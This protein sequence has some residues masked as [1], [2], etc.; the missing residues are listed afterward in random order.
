MRGKILF[1]LVLLCGLVNEVFGCTG[2]LLTSEDK[3]PVSGRTVEFGSDIEMSLAVIPRNYTFTGVTPQG[4]GLKYTAK[5]GA[6]GIYCFDQQVLM[7]GIN[8]KG[9]VAAAFYFPG[10]ASY[11]TITKQNQS[12]ALSPVEFP[13]WILTQFSTIEEVKAALSSVVI[14]PTVFKSW[15]T[16][17]PPMHY[18][19]YDSSGKSLVIEPLNGTL[20]HHENPL[21]TFTNSPTFDWHL[22][23]LRN[24][25]NLSIYNVDPT[26]IRDLQLAPFGQGSGLVGLPGDFT[27]PSRFVRA[28]LFSSAALPT[29]TSEQAVFETF[30]LLNQFDIPVAAVREKE[31]KGFSYDSTLLTSVKDPKT[32]RYYYRSYADQTMRYIELSQFDL[33][34]KKIYSAKVS[35]VQTAEDSSSG[36]KN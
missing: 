3:T 33:T 26:T 34:S 23:N 30:H 14:A 12:K 32:L 21:G 29:Q 13:N 24:F 7:D 22:T 9:L 35:G 4:N 27:P 18:I 36:L 8:E 11:A 10:Y 1:F 5:Y 17:P 16:T 31:T 25:I 6:A 15:G 20:V 19:V 28:A 2:L